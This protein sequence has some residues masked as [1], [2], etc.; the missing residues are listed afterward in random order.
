M[1]LW[2]IVTISA[3]VAVLTAIAALEAFARR[4]FAKLFS[5]RNDEVVFRNEFKIKEAELN[6]DSAERIM[7]NP[8]EEV[9]LTGEGGV[10]L[11]GIYADNGSS[12]TVVLVHGYAV[13]WKSRAYDAE[14]YLSRGYNVLLTD[15]TGHGRSGGKFI[16]MGYLDARNVLY[17]CD[18]LV[19]AKGARNIILD[20]VSM[21][22]ATVLATSN[23]ERRE[24]VRGIIA[25]CGYTSAR[26]VLAFQMKKRHIP[27]FPVLPRICALARKNGFDL[28]ACSTVEG[29][30][31]SSVPTLF[32]HGSGDRV[33]PVSMTGRLFNANASEREL[34]ITE[35]VGHGLSHIQAKERYGA[36]I[37]DFVKEVTAE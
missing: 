16:T 7:S 36:A 1:P 37:A 31:K 12:V 28:K 13:D 20:G 3:A 14:Q 23:Y 24:A 22:A 27:V 19:R 10:E 18:W 21:G 26:D 4:N 9:S 6:R 15:N 30:R 17:W 5:R 32:I 2:G 8:H 25:D 35:G 33:V 34:L 11:Y 29:V